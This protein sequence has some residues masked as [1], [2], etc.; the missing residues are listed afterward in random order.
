MKIPQA[1]AIGLTVAML[2][3]IPAGARADVISEWNLKAESIAVKKRMPPPPNARAMA[4]LH[5]AMFEAVNAAE[6]RYA[7]YGLNLPAE[8]GISKEAAAAQAAYAV[9]VAI[10]P[11]EQS[12]LGP[13]LAFDL[14]KVPQGDAKAKGIALGN[15]AAAA[16]LALRA[17]DGASEPETYRP[18]TVAGT[19]VP[20]VIPISSTVGRITPWVMTSGAQFRPAPPPALSSATWARDVNEIKDYGGHDGSKR[21]AEQTEIGRF[22]F[23]TGP[24]AWNPIVRQ[25]ATAKKLDIVDS[26][27]LFALVAMATNDA[28]IAVFDA[29]YHYN[30]W[31]PVT[32]IRNADL[33]DNPATQR[34]Q[35]WLPLGDTP[36]H[37]E[38]PCAHCITSSAA[39]T[40]LQS[41][42]GNDIP[43]V[44]MT[45]AS[46]PGVTRRWTK[47]QDYADEVAVARIY[48]G[49]HYRFSNLTGQDMGR[50]IAEL[51]VQT[52][53][54]S[55]SA[56][57]SR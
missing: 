18:H 39:A 56:A 22:W 2:F 28:F 25:L 40:V 55:A 46:A 5:V 1:R 7:G 54:R 26:A 3:V 27:R 14:D 57:P 4:I 13:A 43:E 24:Q 19:Y 48:G 34:D 29:K 12:A 9:L 30:F 35:R 6:R 17:N 32:A 50:K 45:S 11:D 8:R 23:V 52:Q 15:K 44:S 53:L 31:R 49:F 36:M 37:P 16:V 41:V 42:F 47:L 10:H 38:Y 20:T 21:S 51:A 33:S